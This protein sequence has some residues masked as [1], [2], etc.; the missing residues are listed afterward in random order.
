MCRSSFSS[1]PGVVR[2]PATFLSLTQ[3]G[4][5]ALV[6]QQMADLALGIGLRSLSPAEQF[7]NF[8]S[9]QGVVY[10]ALLVTFVAMPLLSRPRL[11]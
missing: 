7:A 5:G 9:P 11:V 10:G 1:G 3:M 8:A 6:L 4:L 2:L